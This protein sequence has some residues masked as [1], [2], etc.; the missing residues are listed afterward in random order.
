MRDLY[1]KP[2]SLLAVGKGFARAGGGYP[3]SMLHGTSNA[4]ITLIHDI[5]ALILTC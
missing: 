3:S 1:D 5:S 4:S 2:A